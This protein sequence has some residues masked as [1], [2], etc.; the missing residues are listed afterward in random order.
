MSLNLLLAF[1]WKEWRDSPQMRAFFLKKMN[2]EFSEL[3]QGR[4]ASKLIEQITIEEFSLGSSLPVIKG[5]PQ[6]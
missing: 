6:L 5:K 1:L 3:M 4:T 2:F